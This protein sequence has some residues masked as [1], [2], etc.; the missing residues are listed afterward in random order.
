MLYISNN[1]HVFFRL[2]PSS[3]EME[4]YFMLK[5]PPAMSLVVGQVWFLTWGMAINFNS[6]LFPRWWIYIIEKSVEAIK[7]SSESMQYIWFDI[8]SA[9]HSSHAYHSYLALLIINRAAVC[10]IFTTKF[11]THER[12]LWTSP[13]ASTHQC[14]YNVLPSIEHIPSECIVKFQ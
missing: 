5:L 10:R 2:W 13:H 7:R 9:A 6:V 11:L 12:S 8:L 14:A 4:Y 3:F 1:D